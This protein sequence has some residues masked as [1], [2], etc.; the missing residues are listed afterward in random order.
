MARRSTRSTPLGWLLPRSVRIPI[1]VGG[2][3]F[4]IGRNTS[5]PVL[6][7]IALVL[8]IV[9]VTAPRESGVGRGRGSVVQPNGQ[10]YL[11][12]FWNVENLFDDTN[13][14]KNHDPLEDWFAANPRA[15]AYKLDLLA[16]SLLAMNGGRGPDLL[17]L[18][19]V[20]N[21]R[22]VELLRDRLHREL[23]PELHYHD[24]AHHD[25]ITGRRIEPAILS[26][27]PINHA[28]TRTFGQRRIIQAVV[29]VEGDELAII[30]SHWTS[31][32]TDQEGTK[33]FD[34]GRACLEAVQALRRA[35]LATDVLV[36]GD[37]NDHP[38]YRSLTE[39][40]RAGRSPSAID[41]PVDRF[42]LWNLMTLIKPGTAGTYWYGGG[43]EI[44]DHIVVSPGL[45]D[46]KGWRVLPETLTLGDNSQRQPQRFGGPGQRERRGPSDHLPVS[47]RITRVRSGPS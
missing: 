9:L 41:A 4:V 36:V 28:R 35:N 2:Y 25:L 33:R 7:M 10:G 42:R 47:V 31:R 14:F 30:A 22:A 32:I 11:V 20:E 6:V 24:L 46:Q 21:R 16:E 17:A 5:G 26:R 1:R 18:V 13:D 43:W 44:L 3:R 34:Y 23:P 19:E 12:S 39:G 37:F 8:L 38:E 29:E 45:V 15:L 27:L 40:L